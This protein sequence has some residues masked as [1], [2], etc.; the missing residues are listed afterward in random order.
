M[1][2]IW[3]LDIIFLGLASEVYG[4]EKAKCIGIFVMLKCAA[5][6]VGYWV[7]VEGRRRRKRRQRAWLYMGRR[8]DRFIAGPKRESSEVCLF[9]RS[10]GQNSRLCGSPH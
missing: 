9:W 1:V 7:E 8:R 3:E 5:I 10:P 6:C 2:A 4:G